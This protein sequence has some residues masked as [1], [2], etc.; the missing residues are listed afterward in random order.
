MGWHLRDADPAMRSCW[1]SNSGMLRSQELERSLSLG[2]PMVRDWL[3][4]LQ[5]GR[6]HVP[7]NSY[8]VAGG[9]VSAKALITWL[10]H[11]LRLPTAATSPSI[12]LQ[13]QVNKQVR[14]NV[15]VVFSPGMVL[16]YGGRILAES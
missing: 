1:R 7:Q 12:S 13:P 2:A 5:G 8:S 11:D 16:G 3:Q 14:E 10:C 6:K 4:V 9:A 15:Y